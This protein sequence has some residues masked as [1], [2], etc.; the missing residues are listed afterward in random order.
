MRRLNRCDESQ[1]LNPTATTRS[2]SKK[3]SCPSN[4][5]T[6]MCLF[7]PAR[8]YCV[9]SSNG[10]PVQKEF[11]WKS[12]PVFPRLTKLGTDLEQSLFDGRRSFG[13]GSPSGRRFV[14][15]SFQYETSSAVIEPFVPVSRRIG[16]YSQVSTT[17]T[18]MNVVAGRD[19]TLQGCHGRS[20]AF[21][22]ESW[23]H[24]ERSA[25]PH[26]VAVT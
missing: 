4:G 25:G 22:P 17:T 24:S 7:F 6:P 16:S 1:P 3:P 20:D 8:P 14:T 11:V 9:V 15:S 5:S 21:W 2:T 12:E 13:E 19:I 18:V 23:G 10:D 26:S